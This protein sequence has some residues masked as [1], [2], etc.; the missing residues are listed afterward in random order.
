MWADQFHFRRLVKREPRVVL[1][2]DCPLDLERDRDLKRLEGSWEIHETPRADVH[3]LVY[4]SYIDIGGVIPKAWCAWRRGA[5]SARMG[6]RLRNW[7]EGRPMP[8]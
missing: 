5:K 4:E 6:E 1:G 3:M 2:L 7:I 8:E